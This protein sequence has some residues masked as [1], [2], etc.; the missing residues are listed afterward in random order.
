M[1]KFE[2]F[3]NRLIDNKLK[4][5][6]MMITIYMAFAYFYDVAKLTFQNRNFCDFAIY[7]VHTKNLNSGIDTYSIGKKELLEDKKNMG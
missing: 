1:T 3:L 5:L 7:Y 4:T 2:D 6:L